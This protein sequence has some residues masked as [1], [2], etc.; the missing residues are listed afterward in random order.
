[1]QSW[2]LYHSLLLLI[3]L[4]LW[5]AVADRSPDHH[6][7]SPFSVLPPE[8]ALRNFERDLQWE[9]LSTDFSLEQTLVNEPLFDGNSEYFGI[10]DVQVPP[11]TIICTKCCTHG[12]IK[13]TLTG[14]STRDAKIRF[15][16]TNVEG[17]IEL[18]IIT[19]SIVTF[20]VPLFKTPPGPLGIDIPGGP[21]LGLIFT[22]DMIFAVGAAIDMHGGFFF[23][24]ADKSSFEASLVNG[25]L[26]NLTLDGIRGKDLPIT[27]N[28]SNSSI[29]VVADLQLKAQIAI[30]T[31]S[32]LFPGFDASA[33]VGVYVNLVEY[34][35]R[36]TSV[37]E[38]CFMQ[39][40]Q[41]FNINV[42]AF[43]GAGIAI[44]DKSIG[45][46][47]TKS[48]TIYIADMGT[49]CVMKTG[50]LPTSTAS[51][52]SKDRCV[53]GGSQAVTSTPV[54]P[55]PGRMHLL[56]TTTPPTSSSSISAT[57][58]LPVTSLAPTAAP[59][60]SI[61]TLTSCASPVANCP[62]DLQAV[63]TVAIS[64]CAPITETMASSSRDPA[65]SV[66][67]VCPTVTDAIALTSMA[68]PVIA[69]FSSGCEGAE[70]MGPAAPAI[71]Q[72]TPP[73]TESSTVTATSSTERSRETP[74][75][76][77]TSSASAA[78][79]TDMAEPE[80]ADAGEK[81]SEIRLML[82]SWVTLFEVLVIAVTAL[83]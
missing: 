37:E 46:V 10:F 23:K 44:N 1:M 63:F 76:T 4:P 51:S 30:D 66:S 75:K 50:W 21:K 32:G 20:A 52:V 17:Y 64:E 83:R 3:T 27:I 82:S 26:G 80:H 58:T 79:S 11:V 12:N 25:V 74:G 55:I 31:S 77:S 15:D 53:G 6:D 78:S 18:D 34:V 72:T 5:S 49:S 67:A 70:C 7:V 22:I 28:W 14:T 35:V 54:P 65:A 73:K 36:L 71:M 45:A 41:L 13:A 69:T 47:P 56:N 57:T 62:A 39:A 40:G 59:T 2:A 81:N 61:L 33:A 24:L 48:T 8:L 68:T 42:G 29:N 19:K 38:I 43:M 9:N 60:P 16:L